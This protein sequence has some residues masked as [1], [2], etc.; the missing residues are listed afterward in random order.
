MP[1]DDPGTLEP[2]A[3][4]SLTAYFLYLND[5]IAEDAVM[6]AETLPQVEM[7]ARDKFVV[8]NR[9]GGRELR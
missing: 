9:R 3:V 5:I 1:F 4:Y 8:D 2:T 7:P 6:N